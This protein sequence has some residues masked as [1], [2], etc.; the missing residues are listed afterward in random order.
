MGVYSNRPHCLVQFDLPPGTHKLTLALAQYKPVPHQVDYTLKVFSMATFNLRPLPF[1]MRCSERVQSA[2][3]GLSAGGCANFDTFVDNPQFA[4]VVGEGGASAD[5]Q[6]ELCG[7]DK[8]SVG[9]ELHAQDSAHGKVRLAD[10]PSARL[11]LPPAPPSRR[12]LS[13]RPSIESLAHGSRRRRRRSPP[14]ARI[15]RASACSRRAG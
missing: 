8:F 5:V 1:S 14:P 6:I 15:A 12:L 2:W 10:H 11:P 9:M 13:Q 3:R 7:P 4:L